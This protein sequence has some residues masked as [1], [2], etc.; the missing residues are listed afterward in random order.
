M[1]AVVFADVHKSYSSKADSGGVFGISLEV[2]EGRFTTLV[3]ASG[4]GKT[5]MLRLLAGFL[6]PSSGEIF[7]GG[8]KVAGADCFFPPNRRDLAMVFQSYA[9]WPHMTVHDNVAFG[10]RARKTPAGQ[11]PAMVAQALELVGL[12]RHSARH[13][14]EL[15]GGQQQRVALARSVVL[16]PRLLLL[17]EPLSNLDAD[18]RVQMRSQL[19]ELQSATGITFVYVTHDQDEAFALSDYL[20]VLEAGRVLQAGSPEDLYYRPRDVRVARFLNRGGLVLEGHADASDG[21][22]TFRCGGAQPGPVVAGLPAAGATGPGHLVLRAEALRL[23]LDGQEIPAGWSSLPGTATAIAFAG[24][25]NQVRVQVM[26]QAAA[27]LYDPE[28]RSVAVGQPIR[29]AFRPQDGRFVPA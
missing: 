20:V 10:L 18:L 6:R 26:P 21:G 12:S 1:S 2:P 23:V 3:G 11:I 8:E 9:L 17:D 5:T 29:I 27:T 15:S 13:P 19:K 16:R 14:G 22:A 28:R 24:R 7:I 25:E 4:S